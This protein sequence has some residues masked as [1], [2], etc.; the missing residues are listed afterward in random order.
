MN[1][2]KHKETGTVVTARKLEDHGF[3]SLAMDA[4]ALNTEQAVRPGTRKSNG[5]AA[6]IGLLRNYRPLR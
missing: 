5:L 3:E 4:N 1:F 2:F 6:G